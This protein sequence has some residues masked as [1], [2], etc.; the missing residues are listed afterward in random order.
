MDK[1]IIRMKHK[2]DQGNERSSYWVWFFISFA[3]KVVLLQKVACEIV[4]FQGVQFFEYSNYRESTVFMN[5]QIFF[6]RN[7]LQKY[8]QVLMLLFFSPIVVKIEA[9]SKKT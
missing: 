8:F 3:Q 6:L 1:A 2:F 4:W 5:D 7:I 9:S